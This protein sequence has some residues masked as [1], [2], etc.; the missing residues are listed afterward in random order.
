MLGDRSG[1]GERVETESRLIESS[2]VMK[3]REGKRMKRR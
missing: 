1:R 2:S 3:G